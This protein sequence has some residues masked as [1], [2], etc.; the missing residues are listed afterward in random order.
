[1]FG[2]AEEVVK[3]LE[4]HQDFSLPGGAS[5]P[6]AFFF[7][8]PRS[9]LKIWLNS[10]QASCD[11]DVRKLAWTSHAVFFFFL[12]SHKRCTCNNKKKKKHPSLHMKVEQS[13]RTRLA[14]YAN[15]SP[16]SCGITISSWIWS[17]TKLVTFLL[18]FCNLCR[19]FKKKKKVYHWTV[20]IILS[21]YYLTIVDILPFP[22][23]TWLLIAFCGVMWQL[24][25]ARQS[26]NGLFP[27]FGF[28]KNKKNIHVVL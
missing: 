14:P 7:L 20:L 18:V 25:V 13:A 5:R 11:R 22:E 19:M 6:N 24:P 2:V 10:A 12:T 21:M 16:S 15:S 23:L 27:T 9:L 4:T 1:M 28:Q 8:I 26:S 3:H 17:V